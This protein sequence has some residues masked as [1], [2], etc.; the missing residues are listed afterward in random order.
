[1]TPPELITAPTVPVVALSDLKAH[2]REDHADQDALITSLEKAAVAYLDGWSG[3]L[4]RAIQPQVWRQEYDAGEPVRLSMPDVTG[5][6]VTA[7]DAAGD[8]VNV[9]AVLKRS[10]RG[11]Y[12]DVTG[13]YSMLRVTYTCALSA[14]KLPVAQ[15]VVRLLVGHWFNSPEGV[16]TGFSVAELPLAVNDLV[17]AMRWT[18]F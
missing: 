17:T 14:T 7:F 6:V 18:E 2:L 3:V 12:V 1:M 13:S 5:I 16:A 9:E 4:G 8:A 15:H 11:P 10:A